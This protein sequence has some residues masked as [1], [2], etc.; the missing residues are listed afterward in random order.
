MYRTGTVTTVYRYIFQLINV[1]CSFL[2][3]VFFFKYLGS[4]FAFLIPPRSASA[5][6][7]KR[8]WQK[9]TYVHCTVQL[10]Q[11]NIPWKISAQDPRGYLLSDLDDRVLQ[12]LKF[13][14]IQIKMISLEMLGESLP[15]VGPEEWVP[16]SSWPD[17]LVCLVEDHGVGAHILQHRHRLNGVLPLCPNL[18]K[19]GTVQV[20][21]WK[22]LCVICLPQSVLYWTYRNARQCC[23]TVCSLFGVAEPK[24]SF[25]GWRIRPRK[26]L[27][28]FVTFFLL[29]LQ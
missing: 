15:D 16:L 3:N 22:L 24:P 4:G 12:Y 10:W 6:R 13:C 9:S 28:F 21:T 19:F 17:A 20:S 11:W 8:R 7:L 1:F 25:L 23:G 18:W 2:V 14:N 5:P 27:L 26:K 29:L